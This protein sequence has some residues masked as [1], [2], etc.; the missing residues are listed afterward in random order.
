MT[1]KQRHAFYGNCPV[2]A[3]L[4]IIG[5]KWKAILI[6]HILDGTKRFGE[7]GRLLLGLTQRMLTTQL[8]E[9]EADGV[10]LRTVCPQ[11]PPKVEYS[12]TPFGRTLEPLLRELA[13]WSDVHVKPRLKQ[14][15]A[16]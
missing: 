9:L 11:V 13:V 5:G 1:R 7:F 3:A 10:I 14:P 4:D 12:I 2:E 8:R 16:P 15:E 6:F